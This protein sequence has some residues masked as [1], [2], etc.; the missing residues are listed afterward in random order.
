MRACHTQEG[1]LRELLFRATAQQPKVTACVEEDAGGEE[2]R[3]DMGSPDTIHNN[4]SIRG[5]GASSLSW[6]SVCVMVFVCQSGT[7]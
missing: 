7:F 4:G 6:P 2:R 5:R 1:M 3:K